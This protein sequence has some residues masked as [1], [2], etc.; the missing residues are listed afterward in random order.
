MREEPFLGRCRWLEALKLQ[1]EPILL[2]LFAHA[3]ISLAG[4]DAKVSDEGKTFGA[5]QIEELVHR[6]P[7]AIV[8][9]KKRLIETIAKGFGASV[10]SIKP[11][12]GLN[13][14]VCPTGSEDCRTELES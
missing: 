8:P 11:N 2:H 9:L 4:T 5:K 1:V 12:V 3:V 14:F 13:G 6:T 7:E 10:E